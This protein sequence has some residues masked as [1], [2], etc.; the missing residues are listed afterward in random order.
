MLI[1]S[2]DLPEMNQAVTPGSIG[3][4]SGWGVIT[5][6]GSTDRQLQVVEVPIVSL[7]DCRQSYGFSRIT[8]RMICAGFPEG[9][10]D[11]CDVR[12]LKASNCSFYKM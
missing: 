7:S 2:V 10:K 5:E 1:G 9:G 3:H 11:R 4:I 6:S 8:D 12:F